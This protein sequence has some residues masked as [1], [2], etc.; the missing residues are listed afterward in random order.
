M[1]KLVYSTLALTLFSLNFGCVKSYSP[2]FAMKSRI[3]SKEY[4]F[5]TFN[6]VDKSLEFYHYL[7]KEGYNKNNVAIVVGKNTKNSR[8]YHAWVILKNPEDGKWYRQDPTHKFGDG[9]GFEEKGRFVTRIF[10]KDISKDKINK[11]VNYKSDL[12]LTLFREDLK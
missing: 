6:C 4:N 5:Q 10:T 8:E 7:I 11:W 1:R 3:E 9:D 2:E 12:P